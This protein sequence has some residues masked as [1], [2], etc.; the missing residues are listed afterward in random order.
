MKVEGANVRLY[1]VTDRSWLCERQ[2]ADDVE[3]AL[4]GGVTFLQFREKELGDEAF[5]EEARKIQ[6]LAKKFHVPFLVNDRVEIAKACDADGVHVGQED[7]G[8]AYARQ[9]L[10]PDKIVGASA[11]NV[12][13]A[14]EAEQQGADYLGVGAVFGSETKKNVSSMPK[15]TLKA[16]CEAVDIPVVAIGG[17]S[18]ENIG[19]LRGTG[20]EGV[21]VVSAIFSKKDIKQAA[22]KMLQKI[23]EVLQ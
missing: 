17:I 20:I 10:G 14:V 4:E 23:K 16:I 13:E 3:K 9:V 5:L 12:E 21:A 7:A 19:Q 18:M 15:E 11:H 6:A 2:L 8:V 22:N 1:A